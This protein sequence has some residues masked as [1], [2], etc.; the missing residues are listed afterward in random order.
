MLVGFGSK[1]VDC[2]EAHSQEE[3][4]IGLS[5]MDALGEDQGMVFAYPDESQRSFWMPSSMK[6]AIDIV[7]VGANRKVTRIHDSCL[8]GSKLRFSG[9]AQWVVEVPA[10]FCK[11]NAVRLGQTVGFDGEVGMQEAVQAD[12]SS[13]RLRGLTT[14]ELYAMRDAQSTTNAPY[15]RAPSV[16]PSSPPQDRFKDRQIPADYVE[17]A[18]TG[19][20]FGPI[21][22]E[23]INSPTKP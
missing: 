11:K 3:Q 18:G 13:D 23:N 9:L 8:P 20:D 1:L 15:Q 2:F 5:E 16:A 10:G 6:F 14:A 17:D 19:F 21:R 7:F 4:R 12:V 22:D